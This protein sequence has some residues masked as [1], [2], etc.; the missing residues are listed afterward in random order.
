MTKLEPLNS[1]SFFCRCG[2]AQK[3]TPHTCVDSR[4]SK[5]SHLPLVGV[6]LM[7]LAVVIAGLLIAGSY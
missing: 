3:D 1:S 6:M 7:C 5:V 2:I 4:L